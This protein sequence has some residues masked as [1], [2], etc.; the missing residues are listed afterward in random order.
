MLAARYLYVQESI[1]NK[2][3][4]NLNHNYV[5]FNSQ[6]WTQN[7]WKLFSVE[8]DDF[9]TQFHSEEAQLHYITVLAACRK[10]WVFSSM[11][12]AWHTFLWPF[13]VINSCVTAIDLID[14]YLIYGYS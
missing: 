11:T 14:L 2:R 5:H 12:V 1:A 13:K 9:E 7:L 8:S 10:S 4:V 3:A 6:T